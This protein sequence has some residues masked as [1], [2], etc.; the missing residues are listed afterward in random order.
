VIEVAAGVILRGDGAFLLACRP[1]G[2][3]YAGWWEFPGGKIESGEAPAAALARELHEEL[4]ID[5]TDAWPWLTR[6]H[7]YAHGTVRLRFFRVTAWSGTPHPREGQRIL[8]QIP[9]TPVAAP[10]LAANAPVLQALALPPEYAVTSA[11]TF[12]VAG[13]LARLDQRLAGGLRL[14]Q[15]RDHGLAGTARE[16]F[17]RAVIAR[18]HAVGARVL[19][20]GELESARRLGADGVHLTSRRLMECATRPE[21]MLLGASCHTGDELAQAM[22]LGC[23]LAVLGPVAPTRSHPDALPLG[24]TGF[25][26]LAQGAS[27]P[28]YAIGGLLPGD[29]DTARSAGAHGLAMIGGSWAP[30]RIA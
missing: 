15:V 11:E 8:W 22:R 21:G 10:M 20:N 23:D 2:K 13:M 17:A 16:D 14:V 19:L 5:V 28:V 25:A 12:G 29:L 3:V 30:G 27:L 9:G 24:W 1:A 7:A 26:R 18:A 6:T 4:G